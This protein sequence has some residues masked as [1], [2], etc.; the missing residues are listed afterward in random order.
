MSPSL[1]FRHGETPR[2]NASLSDASLAEIIFGGGSSGSVGEGG[3]EV[4]VR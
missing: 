2:A 1:L 4:I 3:G